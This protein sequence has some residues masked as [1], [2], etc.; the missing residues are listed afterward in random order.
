MNENETCDSGLPQNYGGWE[1][2]S[3]GSQDSC[4]YHKRNIHCLISRENEAS[5]FRIAIG[6][7][8]PAGATLAEMTATTLAEALDKMAAWKAKRD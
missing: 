4:H 7:Y 3:C 8:I 5:P 2:C 6:I 1:L